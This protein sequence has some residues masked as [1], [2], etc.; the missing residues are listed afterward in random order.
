M[1]AVY[2]LFQFLL[3]QDDMLISWR[4]NSTKITLPSNNIQQASF[5]VVERDEMNR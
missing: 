5:L 1:T 2:L 3:Q 4:F